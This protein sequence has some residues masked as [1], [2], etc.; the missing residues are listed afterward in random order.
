MRAEIKRERTIKKAL[1]LL[2][3][4]CVSV[5]FDRG[6]DHDDFVKQQ[7]TLRIFAKYKDKP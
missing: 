5:Q 3:S 2:C 6:L 1:K 7:T 4:V